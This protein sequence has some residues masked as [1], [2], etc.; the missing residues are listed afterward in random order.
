MFMST[1]FIIED[2]SRKNNGVMGG[3]ITLH[4]GSKSVNYK[5]MVLRLE[6]ANCEARER[7]PAGKRAQASER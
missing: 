3:N 1:G 7:M 6:G 2:F 5:C 4:F